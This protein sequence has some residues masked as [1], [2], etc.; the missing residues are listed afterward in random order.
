MP[1]T[2]LEIQKLVFAYG[3]G[4]RVLNEVDLTVNAGDFIALAG[5]NGSGKTTL[6][7][8][9]MSLLKPSGGTI[10]FQGKDTAVMTTADMARSVGYVF[11][12]PDRQ[13]FRDTVAQEVAYGPEQLRF[14]P[15]VVNDSVAWALSMTG[16]TELAGRFPRLLS[17]GQKQ[18]IAI[19]SAIAMRPQMLI[20]DEP[21]SGQDPWEAQNMMELLTSLNQQGITIILVTHDMELI[22]QYA[23][24]AI[25][26]DRGHKV[27][28]GTP[29][30]LFN[31]EIDI[32]AWG[33]IPPTAVAISR[34]L[35]GMNAQQVTELVRQVMPMIQ[36][37]GEDYS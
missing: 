1:E 4:G 22:G 17:R 30:T 34:Q 5:R 13:I 18:R 31:G 27:F 16:L 37:G 36:K 28:D 10:Y 9:A 19:A 12:N 24:R 15:A 35:P 25:V 26:L 14:S 32:A 11:Q 29:A 21:T 23:S 2:L 6:T 33:L 7:R 20:L 8:L 3:H